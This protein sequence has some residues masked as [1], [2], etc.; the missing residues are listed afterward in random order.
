[1][2]VL[3]RGLLSPFQRREDWNTQPSVPKVK[4][5]NGEVVRS[6]AYLEVSEGLPFVAFPLGDELS[7]DSQPTLEGG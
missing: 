4:S 3:Y 5:F 2:D 6:K 1:M 7:E